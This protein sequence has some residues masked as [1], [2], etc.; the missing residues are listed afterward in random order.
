MDDR[1]GGGM[2]LGGSEDWRIGG[3]EDRRMGK[4]GDTGRAQACE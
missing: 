3:S 2:K 1:V 4:I